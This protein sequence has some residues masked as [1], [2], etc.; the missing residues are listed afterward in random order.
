MHIY[1]KMLWN[2]F[3]NN[4]N[5]NSYLPLNNTNPKQKSNKFKKYSLHLI[6]LSIISYFLFFNNNTSSSPNFH[7]ITYPF[8]LGKNNTTIL[9]IIN[10]STLHNNTII[11]LQNAIRMNTEILDDFPSPTEEPNYPG[12]LNFKKFHYQLLQDFPLVFSNLKIDYINN[13]ALLFTW[14]GTDTNLKPVMFAAHQDT[15]P[16]EKTTIN[17]WKYPPFDAHFDGKFI[18]GRGSLD[19]KNMLIGILQT[20]EYLLSNEPDFSPKRTILFAVGCDEEASGRYGAQ[21]LRDTILKR[22]GNYGIYSI[23]DEGV[24]GIRN[25]SNVLISAPSITEKGYL[26]MNFEITTQGGHSSVPPDHTSIGIAAQ[27]INLLEL[28]K[29]PATFT[30]KNPITTLFQCVAENSNTLD[31]MIKKDLLNAM[32]DPKANKRTLNHLIASSREFEYLFRT[33]KAIDMINGGVKA[34][35]LP[36]HVSFLLNSRINVDSNLNI[37]IDHILNHVKNIAQ[38]FN[39]S[40]IFENKTIIANGQ[41]LINITTPVAFNPAPVS[42]NNEIWKEFAGSINGFYSD[43]VI[44]EKYPQFKDLPFIVAP[45]I[46]P[47]N[48]D[49]SKYW[50]LTRNIYRYQPGFMDDA[51]MKSIHSVN[52][53]VDVSM[54]MEVIGFFYNYIHIVNQNVYA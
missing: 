6:G 25:M 22:Y 15:V 29:F 9:N 7:C 33:S 51:T 36:E 48:T 52:E 46:M 11:K 44:P 53:R 41:G 47:A 27:L 13:Y 10:N 30:D 38:T 17:D 42:P 23:I 5:D 4:N 31:P 24:V 26:N 14:N 21:F 1:I 40:V 12:W 49:T 35:A 28:D 39:L 32:N 43:I 8:I 50:N 45:S 37:T 20:L 16:V 54:V 34:N 2:F 3:N 19:D 18:W